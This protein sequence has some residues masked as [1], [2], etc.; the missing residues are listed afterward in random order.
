M[1]NKVTFTIDGV[2]VQADAGETIID[3]A[4]KAGVYIPRLCHKPG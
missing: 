2:E 1:T 3:A 4:D